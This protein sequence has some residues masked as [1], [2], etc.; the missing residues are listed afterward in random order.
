LIS[1]KNALCA[2]QAE[3][4]KRTQQVNSDGKKLSIFAQK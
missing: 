4:G 3:E 1:P 2:H